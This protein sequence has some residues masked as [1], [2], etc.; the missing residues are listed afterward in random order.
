MKKFIDN[1]FNLANQKRFTTWLD[2]TNFFHI[3]FIWALIIVIFGICY[4]ILRTDNTLLYYISEKENV[5]RLTDAIYFSFVT[6]TSTGFGD[7][8]PLGFFKL[9]AVLEVI[10]GL[11]LLAFVTSK[12]VSIKQ[13]VILTEIYDL[14]FNEKINRIRASMLFFRQQIS[15]L[16]AHIESDTIKKGRLTTFISS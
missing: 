10:F 7:I 9:M 8:I 3:F 13:D 5:T 1:F 15:R 2:K 14:S 12:L 11:M 16:I 6:A 4:F